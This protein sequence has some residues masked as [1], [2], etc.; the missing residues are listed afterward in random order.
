MLALKGIHENGVAKLEKPFQS[1]KKREVMVTFLEE[2][3]AKGVLSLEN[4]SFKKA[5]ERTSQ[6]KFSLSDAVIEERREA[7]KT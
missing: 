6:Y 5:R 4:F 1:N 7:E 3:R 2:D